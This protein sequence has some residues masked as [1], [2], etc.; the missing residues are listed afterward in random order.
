MNALSAVD[1]E[2]KEAVVVATTD[3]NLISNG[4][5]V[6][7]PDAEWLK[8]FW[9]RVDRTD[10][11]WTWCGA[12]HTFGYGVVSFLGRQR[13]VHRLVYMMNHGRIPSG[14]SVLHRCDNPPCCR[15]DHL[16]LG[17]QLDNVRDMASKKRYHSY[18]GEHHTLAAL[19]N[20]EAA[21]IRA[22]LKEGGI[23]QRQLARDYGVSNMTVWSI[24]NGKSYKEAQP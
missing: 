4:D 2:G 16:F 7:V 21:R 10:D 17:S 9:A 24:A 19:T 23:S 8:R 15:P 11:C 6:L 12:R 14:M 20:A 3:S 22:L 1:A 18:P 5:S 13:Y